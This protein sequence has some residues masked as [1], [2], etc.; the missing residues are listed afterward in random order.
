MF[1]DGAN[2]SYDHTRLLGLYIESRAR[3]LL[4]PSFALIKESFKSVDKDLIALVIALVSLLQ[5]SLS[6][7]L[8]DVLNI[9]NVKFKH[10]CSH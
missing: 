2:R 6:C 1:C 9:I 8:L 10:V 4:C 3:L 7:I 5:L